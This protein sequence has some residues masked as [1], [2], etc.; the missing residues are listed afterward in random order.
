LFWVP[1]KIGTVG[2]RQDIEEQA[3]EFYGTIIYFFSYGY[4]GKFKYF[5]EGGVDEA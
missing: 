3:T 4:A 2:T 1:K 5:L